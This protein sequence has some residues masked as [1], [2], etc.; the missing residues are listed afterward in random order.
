VRTSLSFYIAV[1]IWSH[2]SHR[3]VYLLF[4]NWFIFT[5][6]LSRDFEFPKCALYRLETKLVVWCDVWCRNGIQRVFI[7]TKGGLTRYLTLVK[8]PIEPSV[9][10]SL[11]AAVKMLFFYFLTLFIIT[12]HLQLLGVVLTVLIL[13]RLWNVTLIECLVIAII[14]QLCVLLFYEQIKCLYV[15]NVTSLVHSDIVIAVFF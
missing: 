1:F 7:G 5:R 13:H 2:L 9:P 8:D 4:F 3:F 14:G 11:T 15:C 12:L 10:F 6:V